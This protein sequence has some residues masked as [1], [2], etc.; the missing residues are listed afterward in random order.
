MEEIEEKLQIARMKI[1][2]KIPPKI[3]KIKTFQHIERDDS[4]QTHGCID[5]NQDFTRCGI[6]YNIPHSLEDWRDLLVSL[7]SPL[8][9]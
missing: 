7:L 2:Q 8:T 6:H 9:P 5:A 4:I 3:K 1:G